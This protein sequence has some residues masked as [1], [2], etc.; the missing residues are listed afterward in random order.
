MNLCH[1][2]ENGHRNC[3]SYAADCR[4]Y[5]I[6]KDTDKS[7]HYTPVRPPFPL[8]F[9]KLVSLVCHACPA[10]PPNGNGRR[11]DRDWLTPR[12]PKQALGKRS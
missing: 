6:K 9:A 4:S 2:C 8:V 10:L 7:C 1:N 11:A 3:Q 5:V 12:K